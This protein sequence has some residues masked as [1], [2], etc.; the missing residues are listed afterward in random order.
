MWYVALSRIAKMQADEIR[1]HDW[2]DAHKRL[3]R[4]G[5][6]R[7]DDRS[8]SEQMLPDE[9]MR[10]RTNAMWVTAQVHAYLDPNFNV[11]EYA[12]TCGVTGMTP[13]SLRAGLRKTGD[14]FHRPGTREVD[15]AGN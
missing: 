5:H 1:E 8:A 10:V 15:A 2:S 11:V 9:A 7:S 3:D 4:A 6:R 12:A 13:D 14:G